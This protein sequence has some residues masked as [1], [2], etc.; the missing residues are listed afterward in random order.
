MDKICRKIAEGILDGTLADR[1]AIQAEKI[2][3]CGE[4]RA[5]RMPSNSEILELIP[6]D[7]RTRCSGC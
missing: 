7:R 5:E 1:D 6:E 2:R 3:L 4:A